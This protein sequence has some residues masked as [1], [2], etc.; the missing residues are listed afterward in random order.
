MASTGTE[1]RR[2]PSRLARQMGF[3]PV[4]GAP[5]DERH[6]QLR[7]PL[8]AA[9]AALLAAA[10]AAALLV[11]TGKRPSVPAGAAERLAGTPAQAT[12]PPSTQD[13]FG[14]RPPGPAPWPATGLPAVER[15]VWRGGTPADPGPGV[16]AAPDT[17]KV[18][19]LSFDDGPSPVWTPQILDILQ[20]EGIHA[21]F[22]L[23]GYE[24]L[25]YRAVAR[26]ELATG[27][28]ICDH[29]A[30][31]NEHLDRATP[32]VVEMEI[33]LGA[34]LIRTAIGQDPV[35]YR[36][37]ANALS[38]FIIQVAHAR[39]L[40]VLSYSVDPS[41]YRRPAAAVLL[42][43]ILARVRPGSIIVLHDGGGDRSQTVAV[44]KPL[45]DNLKAQGYRFTTVLDE[46]STG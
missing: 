27:Q 3:Q 33:D 42:P 20:Q 16:A 26:Q 45:I 19:E 15:V 11:T 34:D 25:R 2:L 38:P 5:E 9:A 10:V 4:V 40:R 31:H 21:T 32:D 29:T 6:D 17:R 7:V 12:I 36:P 30:H 13:A 18:V 41:D 8:A 39:H 43:R 44:L 46:P 1:F 14:A 35:C 28:A 23:I 24:A 37:P 22:S